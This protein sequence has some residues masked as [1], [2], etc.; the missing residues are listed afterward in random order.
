MLARLF[1]IKFASG[2]VNELLS[3]EDPRECR[4]PSGLI[5]LEYRKLVQTIEYEECR[6]VHE[7]PF[8]IIFSQDLKVLFIPYFF[9]SVSP[10]YYYC[11]S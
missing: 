7:G 10:L 5:V 4:V 1:E 6:V 2:F 11:F 9:F 3:L 8:R